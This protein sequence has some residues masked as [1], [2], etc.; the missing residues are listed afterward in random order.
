MRGWMILKV[1]QQQS[2]VDRALLLI[3]TK[4]LFTALC[5]IYYVVDS[6]TTRI[7]LLSWRVSFLEEKAKSAKRRQKFSVAAALQLFKQRQ[8]AALKI[9]KLCALSLPNFTCAFQEGVTPCA[10]GA[11]VSEERPLLLS[12]ALLW[13]KGRGNVLAIAHSN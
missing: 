10:V 13:R 2:L 1:K 6:L 11:V 8:Y 12:Y 7:H 5:L 3:A 9:A 4:L